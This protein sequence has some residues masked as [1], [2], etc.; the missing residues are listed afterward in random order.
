MADNFPG[1]TGDVT[2]PGADAVSITPNDTTVLDIT[3]AIYVGTSGSV[4]VKMKSG[5]TVTF[6][7]VPVGILPIRVQ[8]VLSTGTTASGII[9]L[10]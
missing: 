7:S 2:S 10:Y 6:T 5:A 3:R 1:S 4:A 8:Q 9:A